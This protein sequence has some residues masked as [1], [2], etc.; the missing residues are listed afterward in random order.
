MAQALLAKAGTMQGKQDNDK[1][2]T[3]NFA[4]LYL[5]LLINCW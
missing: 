5:N 1:K 3:N 2:F 4:H